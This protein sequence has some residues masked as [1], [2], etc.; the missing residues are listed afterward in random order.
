MGP[1]D[2]A[3]WAGR[4][5]LLFPIV[6]RLANDAYRHGGQTYVLPKHGF[7][8]TAMFDVVHQ[9][10]DAALF[11]LRDDAATRGAYPFAFE[12]DARFALADATLAMTV[13]VRNCGAT[14]MPASF[15]FHPAFAWPLPGAAARAGH[16]ITFAAAEPAPLAALS[17]D[18]LI[19]PTPRPTPVAGRDL[20]LDDTLFTDDALIWTALN[21]RQLTYGAEGAGQLE[22]AFPDTDMLGV[23]TKP[24]APFVCIEPWA[25]HA[26]PVG[27][28]GD[29]VDKPGIFIVAPGDARSFGMTVALAA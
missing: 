21:S 25:G 7:A 4:A 29:F 8:R 9:A 22:I 13:T 1:G 5:P 18:G 28:A 16:R 20:M 27:Y 26:D 17:P 24:G 14:A 6:G 23:W 15:G 11:R 10:G 12:L 3:S 2:P 19:L